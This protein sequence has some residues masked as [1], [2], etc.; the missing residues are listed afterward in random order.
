[1]KPLLEY[2]LDLGGGSLLQIANRSLSQMMSYI[3]DC[4]EGGTIVIDGGIFCDADADHLY[5][6]LE[7]RGKKV[8]I[9]FFTHCHCDHYGAWKRLNERGGFDIEIGKLCFNFP[10]YEWLLTKE[11]KNQTE[12]LYSLLNKT[13]FNVVTPH[14]GDIFS[15]GGID[16]EVLNEPVNYENYRSIN[17]TGIILKAYFPKQS[18]LFLG[19][20]DEDAEEDYKKLFSVEKLRCDI[21]QMA[22][23]GQEGVSREF[24]EMIRP[25]YCLYC[26]PD[27]LWENNVKSNGGPETRGQGPFLT[28]ETRRWMAEMGVIRSFHMGDGDWLFK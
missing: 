12:E 8:D 20:Y 11:D 3:I 5:K 23:H 27:W 17:P 22:H 16:I 10:R 14:A 18:V 9:W 26:A 15:C 28:L 24:Y 25:K 6:E 19:D 2:N 4:P 7:K 13:S 21:V 1:M